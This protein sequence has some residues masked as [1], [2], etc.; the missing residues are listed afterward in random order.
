MSRNKATQPIYLLFSVIATAGIFSYLL[1]HVSL[2][3]VVELIRNA[4]R[5]AVAMFVV[6][7]LAMSV[8]R[9]WRYDVLLRLSGFRPG[10]TALFLVVLVRNFFSDLLPARIGSLIYIFLITTR[11]GVHA[12]AAASS[13]ALAFLFDTIALVP[14]VL[15]AVWFAGAVGRIPAGGLIAGSVLLAAVT[16]VLMVVLP[17]CFRWGEA[18]WRRLRF[19]P[20]RWLAKGSAVFREAEADTRRAWESGMYFRLL[21]LSVL[22]RVGKY[23]CLYVF[24]FALLRPLGYELSDLSV[25][26]VF[27]GLCASEAAASTPVSGI[28]GFGAYEGTWATVFELLGF[29]GDIAKLTSIS[30]HLFTQVYGYSLGGLALLLLLL[31]VF[32]VPGPVAPG[33]GERDGVVAFY[34]KIAA[35]LAGVGVVVAG[36]YWL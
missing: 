20:E 9:M 16:I 24:L 21:L 8:F 22:V 19:L 7:S 28:A 17:K 2:S 26:R 29:P 18:V 25:S 1:T 23:G 35:V 32:R 33:P 36:L 3:A 11:L 27:L 15:L 31:P 6:L 30:H 14:L 10:R 13:F 34:G 12:G 5:R 4:D